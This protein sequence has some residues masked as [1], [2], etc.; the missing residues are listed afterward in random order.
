META[1]LNN[2][3]NELIRLVRA[4]PEKVK[5]SFMRKVEE[6]REEMEEER[7]IKDIIKRAKEPTI[8]ADE[9]FAKLGFK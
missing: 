4:M 1:L 6:M 3:E 8:P 7:D 5:K 2:E 9:V